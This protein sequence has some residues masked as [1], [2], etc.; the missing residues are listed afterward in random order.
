[1]QLMISPETDVLTYRDGDEHAIWRKGKD[2]QAGDQLVMW[3]TPEG[4]IEPREM[5]EF[6]NL[7]R[8]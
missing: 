4:H 1:M 5:F 3:Q 6:H 8:G 7:K 2:L